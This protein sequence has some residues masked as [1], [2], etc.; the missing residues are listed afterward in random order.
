[1][2]VFER[3]QDVA[4]QVFGAKL[5]EVTLESNLIDDLGADSLDWAEMVIETEEEFNITIDE[6][7]FKKL[8]TIGDIINYLKENGIEDK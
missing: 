4:S 1:M 7:E 5:E 8:Y 6:D 3:L 2:T